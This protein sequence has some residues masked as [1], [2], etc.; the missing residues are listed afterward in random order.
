MPGKDPMAIER[1][2]WERQGH[3]NADAYAAASSVFRASVVLMRMAEE[4][5]RPSGLTFTRFFTLS[6][7]HRAPEGTMLLGELSELLEVRPASTTG[8]ISALESQGYVQRIRSNSDRRFIHAQILPAGRDAV[9]NAEKM[10]SST[11][12]DEMPW[13]KAEMDDLY[14]LLAKVRRMAGD[15]A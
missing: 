15:F 1:E 3:A 8:M 12:L 4:A 11:M 13:T 7:L 9:L 6:A 10:I 2:R 14:E 5:I